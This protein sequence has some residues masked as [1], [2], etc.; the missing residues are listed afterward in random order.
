MGDRGPS[1]GAF[2]RLGVTNSLRSNVM[3]LGVA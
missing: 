1:A 2:A 3:R